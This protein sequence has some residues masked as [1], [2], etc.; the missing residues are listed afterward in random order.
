MIGSRVD[1]AALVWGA[2]F[3]LIGTA[4]LGQEWG[5]WQVRASI[6]MPVLLIVAGTVIL[7]AGLE[8]RDASA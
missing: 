5:W 6:L 3:T 4:F 1:R 2:V 8:R 7:L